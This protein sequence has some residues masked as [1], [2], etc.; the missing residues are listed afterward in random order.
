MTKTAP[1]LVKLTLSWHSN[2]LMGFIRGGSFAKINFEVGALLV[3]EDLIE[4]SWYDIM[5][6]ISL[7]M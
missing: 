3:G 5:L 1:I 6:S 7:S 2:T 4:D